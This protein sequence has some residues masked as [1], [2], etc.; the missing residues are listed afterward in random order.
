MS[1]SEQRIKKINV[2]LSRTRVETLPSLRWYLGPP[3]G[4]KSLNT[5]KTSLFPPRGKSWEDILGTPCS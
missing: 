2:A 3:G 1:Q 4:R 5:N